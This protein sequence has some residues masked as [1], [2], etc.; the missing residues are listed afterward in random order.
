M[1]LCISCGYRRIADDAGWRWRVRRA[2]RGITKAAGIGE[3]WTPRELR[4]PFVSSLSDNEIP[5]EAIADLCGRPWRL[6]GSENVHL[7]RMTVPASILW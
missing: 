6:R 1:A 4:L 5:I 2:L 3:D 7:G